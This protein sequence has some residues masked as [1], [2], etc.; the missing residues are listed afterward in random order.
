MTD[1]PKVLEPAYE[2]VAIRRAEAPDGT[3]GANW[4]QYVIAFEG[5]NSIQG[6]KPG[7]LQTVTEAVDELVAQLNER[8]MGKRGSVNLVPTPKKNTSR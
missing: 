5:G 4:H 3:E 7:N 2:V 1:E 6:Y 8:H